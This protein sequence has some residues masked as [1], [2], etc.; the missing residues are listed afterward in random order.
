MNNK[1]PNFANLRSQTRRINDTSSFHDEDKE[2]DELR[3]RPMLAIEDRHFNSDFQGD[4]KRLEADDYNEGLDAGCEHEL[5][6]SSRSSSTDQDKH[7]YKSK[8]GPTTFSQNNQ[9]QSSNDKVLTCRVCGYSHK[10][11]L[12]MSNHLR[13]FHKLQSPFDQYIQKIQDENN[14]PQSS[15]K[16]VNPNPTQ[17]YKCKLCDIAFEFIGDLTE[18]NEELH[19]DLVW[20]CNMCSFS[21]KW[22]Q[23]AIS[24]LRSAHNCHPPYIEHLTRRSSDKTPTLL[25]HLQAPPENTGSQPIVPSTSTSSFKEEPKNTNNNNAIDKDNDN[26][27]VDNKSSVYTNNQSSNESILKETKIATK[28]CYRK[29]EGDQYQCKTCNKTCGSAQG[30]TEHYEAFHLGMNYRCRLC[31]FTDIWRSMLTKHIKQKHQLGKPYEQYL[32]RVKLETKRTCS[33]TAPI[34]KRHHRRK[35]HL[36]A[37]LE[38]PKPISSTKTSRRK[39]RKSKGFNK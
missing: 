2:K 19:S 24:H 38:A 3:G 15:D 9:S 35:S 8:Q 16:L 10:W 20:A 30:I 34:S 36:K 28:D 5:S 17:N 39:S 12:I 1:E 31:G 18:H 37:A 25:K 23:L 14:I 29:L 33:E 13:I 22:Q 27:D 26:S 4:M 21:N 32:K 11:P 6:R 7:L